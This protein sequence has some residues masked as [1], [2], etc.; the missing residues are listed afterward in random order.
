MKGT[1]LLNTSILVVL[2]SVSIIPTVQPLPSRAD[3]P[4]PTSPTPTPPVEPQIGHPTYTPPSPVALPPEVEE[5]RARQAIEAALAK[6]LRYRGPRYQVAPIEVAVEG[7]WA[8]GVAPWQSEAKTLSGPIH[9]L[10]H[11]SADGTWQALLPGSDELY[12]HWIDA[13]PESLVPAGEKSQLRAQATEAD[14]LQQP[15]ARTEDFLSD[16][17]FV[18]GPNVGKFDVASYLRGVGSPL[19]EYADVIELWCA[20]ASVNPRVVLTLIEMRSGLVRRNSNAN[21]A[22][23]IGYSQLGFEEQVKILVIELAT[24]F[25]EYLYTYGSRSNGLSPT[26]RR[27]D[28]SVKLD[29]GSIITLPINIQAGSYAV[30][31]TLAPISTKEEFSFISSTSASLGFISTYHELFPGDDPLDES[32]QINPMTAPPADLLQF[33]FPVGSSWWFNGPH[34]WNGAGYGPPYSSMDFGTSANSCSSPPT[35]D[36]SVAAAGSSGYHPG[37]YSCWFRVDHGNGWSTSYYHLRNV[38]GNGSISRNDP[39]GTIACET[40]AGGSASAPHVHFSLLYN[41]AYTDLDGTK[42]SGWTIHVG[43]GS[44]NSGYIERDGQTKYPYQYVYNDGIPGGGSTCDA[45]GIPS[46]YTKCAEEGERCNFN[47]TQQVYYGANSCYKV[48]S[49]TN[50][51]DCNNNNFGDPVPGVHKACY[52]PASSSSCDAIN[53]PSGYVKCADENGYCSFSGTQ[54]VYYGADSCYKVR[55][56]TNG[57]GC[58]NGNFGDPLPGV[59]KSCYVLPS[60]TPNADQVALYANTGWG[61]NCITLGVGDYPNPGHLGNLGND[62]AESIRVGSNVQAILY[63]HDNYQGRSETFTNDDSNLGD[64]YIGANTVSSVKVQW[65]AQPPAAPALQSPSN[66]AFFN[67]GQGINFSWS[68]TG[69][70]YYGEIWGGPAG[71]LTFGWQS[72]TS[73]DIGSQWAGYTYSW[74]VKARNGAGESGWSSTWTFTVKPAAPSS[75]DAQTA[76]CN[77]VNLYWNDNSGNEEGYKVYRNGSYVGQVGMNGTSYQD[78][79]LN[80]NTSYSYYVRAFRGSIESDASNTVDITTPSCPPPMPDLRPYAPS[81]YPYPVVPSSIQNTHEVNAL[82]AGQTTYFD[83]YFIN[84]GGSVA[85]ATF[86]VELWVDD[87]RYVRYPQLDFYPGWVG[88]FDDWAETIVTPGWHTVRLIADPDNTVTESD[89]TNNVWQRDFYWAASAPY[90]DDM[91]GGGLSWT[92]TGLWHLVESPYIGHNGSSHAYWYGQDSTGNYDTG[93]ANSGD[94][95]SPPIY[96]PSTGFYLRFWY[97]YETETQG[98]D[99][100]QRWVQISVDGGPFNNVLQLSDDP[101]GWW[102]QGPVINLS[103]YAGHT[104]QVRFHFDTIDEVYNTFDGWYI[105]DFDIS[106]TPPPSC[107]D[108][109]EPNNTP[110]QATAIAYGQTLSADICPGGDY[111]FYTFAGTA[112]DK[113]VIDIDAKVNGSLLDSYI[114]LLDSDGTN[115]LRLNDDEQP[116]SLDSK[117]GYQLPHDGTY[118]IKLKAWNH[119]S[120]GSIDYFYTIHLLTDGVNPSSVAIISPGNDAW[121]DPTLETIT[122]AASDDESGINRVEFLWHDA[123][124]NSDW[125]WLGADYSSDDWSWNFDTDSLPDQRGGAFYVWA[126]DWVGNWTGAGVWNLGIDRT[127]PTV[128][129]DVSLMYGDAPFRDFYIWWYG[130]DNLSDVAN[131]DV[132]Y[133]DGPGGVWTDLLVDTT[134]TSYR[135]VGLDGHT[136]Y[137]R[138]RARDHAGNQ[139]DYSGGNGDTQHTVQTCHVP[140]DTYEADN[141][142]ASARWIRPDAPPQTHNFHNEGDQDWVRFYAAAGITYTL[143][144]TSTSTHADTMIYLYGGDGTTLIDYNDDYPGIW[145]LS[146]LDWRPSTSGFYLVKVQH[147]DPWAYGCTTEYGLSITGSEPTPFYQNYLPLVVRGQ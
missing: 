44:Y 14:T 132:Q 126:F 130:S 1:I 7:E 85:P 110:A 40:C 52:I 67:E 41:G 15:Q 38:R 53:L 104:I 61:G 144:T 10:A 112:G 30:L 48:R 118:Y 101:M 129:A 4:L 20:Y 42:L 95:T 63:E 100:D 89:E 80:G 121:L 145:P 102:L 22:N 46:G 111:D 57:V 16:G 32:N 143:A 137:F 119:P 68:A 47:G 17:Q 49:F 8:H 82:I 133:R 84:S 73:K 74:H 141:T 39:I 36:W 122:V 125:V 146:R 115:V 120:V 117:L 65:R 23:P 13:V 2:L 24:N 131:Y 18:F 127:P 70:E 99:W 12:I 43:N 33:P 83:W 37:D 116:T 6:Y 105:D 134:N 5:S 124:L 135:F 142:A 123:D 19:Y 71:T 59:S 69:N 79:G 26:K 9:I 96:I 92:T 75:L 35:G 108:S 87:T 90:F 78:T 86:Y 66:G 88:G 93:T 28:T 60:C 62:N 58:N 138:A 55:T 136:Y 77:Q 34:N 72:G 51:V 91:E 31:R 3:P 81:G 97:G 29:D 56:Y 109:H 98:L 54:Q 76:S 140:P 94:L 103:G 128:A 27:I 106:T 11:R 139:S 50:G 64:N 107:A 21:V 113:V 25:Y 45:T 147:W 114:F